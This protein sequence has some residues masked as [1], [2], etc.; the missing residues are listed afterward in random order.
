MRRRSRFISNCSGYTT[1]RRPSVR[2]CRRPAPM[3]A[4]ATLLCWAPGVPCAVPVPHHG[5]QQTDEYQWSA[6]VDHNISDKDHGY[7]RVYRDNGFQPTFTSPFGPTFNDQSNQPQMSAQV[8][9][10]HTFNAHHRE[11]IQRLGAVLCGRFSARPTRSAE[12]TALPALVSFRRRPVH[13]DRTTSRSSFR[14]AAVCFSIRSS[15]TCP[16]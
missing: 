2:L 1:A 12:N 6:R 8:S 16:R 5:A 11:S 15:T 9:E 7:V 10:N 4:A 13:R 3:A 14:K